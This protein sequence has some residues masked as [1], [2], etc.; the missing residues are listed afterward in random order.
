MVSPLSLPH[1]S[2]ATALQPPTSNPCGCPDFGPEAAPDECV[3]D[4]NNGLRQCDANC[5]RT[6]GGFPALLRSRG[7]PRS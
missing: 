5:A 2:V 3:G 7:A 4:T 1:E 6:L